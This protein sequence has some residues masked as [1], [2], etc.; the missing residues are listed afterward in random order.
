MRFVPS[1]RRGFFLFGEGLL[2]LDLD[3]SFP[4]TD[5]FL[6]LLWMLELEWRGWCRIRDR[7]GDFRVIL[8]ALSS[9]FFGKGRAKESGL[10]D[11]SIHPL[12]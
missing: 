6:L 12:V 3:H 9:S 10:A 7:K 1:R 11:S 4:F 5:P 2:G 8:L